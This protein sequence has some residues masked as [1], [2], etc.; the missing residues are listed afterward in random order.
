MKYKIYIKVDI[1][2][3]Q[4]EEDANY[5]DEDDLG[6]C[7][8]PLK[9]KSWKKIKT[10]KFDNFTNTFQKLKNGNHFDEDDLGNWKKFDKWIWKLRQ[11][12]I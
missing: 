12:K 1:D 2:K 6:N 8:R 10:T 9:G 3:A 11:L 5:F 4:A 7:L